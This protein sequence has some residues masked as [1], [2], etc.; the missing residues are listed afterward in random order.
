LRHE[1]DDGYPLLLAK[2][3]EAPVTLDRTLS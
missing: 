3:A 1:V 2:I